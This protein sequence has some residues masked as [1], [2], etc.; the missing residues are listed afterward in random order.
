MITAK[1]RAAQTRR[2]PM[3]TGNQVKTYLFFLFPS[4]TPH[5]DFWPQ[6]IKDSPVLTDPGRCRRMAMK[7]RLLEGQAE[8]L[9]TRSCN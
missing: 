9:R 1:K 6:S 5:R 8:Q 2:R 4:T 7:R 3:K